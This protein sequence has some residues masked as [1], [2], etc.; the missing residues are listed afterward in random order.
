MQWKGTQVSFPN[1]F[2]S[3]CPRAGD[4]SICYYS[5]FIFYQFIIIHHLL[6]IS[7]SITLIQ[8]V[9]GGE[10][11]VIYRGNQRGKSA[12]PK[13]SSCQTRENSLSKI[14][15]LIKVLI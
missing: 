2:N 1:Y 8:F 7:Y 13:L 15:I 12:Q 10:E 4:L 5:S 6:S 14:L 11:R 3:I 9:Q